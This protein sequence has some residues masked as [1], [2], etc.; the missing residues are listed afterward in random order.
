MSEILTFFVVYINNFR[1]RG[2]LILDIKLNVR[3]VFKQDIDQQKA[4]I[5]LFNYKL[6]KIIM[7]LEYRDGL[8]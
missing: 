7:Y 1:L 5:E 6:L 2:K 8:V 3:S 4:F